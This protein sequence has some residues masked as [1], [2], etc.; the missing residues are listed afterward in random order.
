[1]MV[2]NLPEC[3]AKK[4]LRNVVI[5][6]CSSFPVQT[7]KLFEKFLYRRQAR[8]QE[9]DYEWLKDKMQEIMQLDKPPNYE[10]FK[11]SN[12]WVSSF[13]DRY[14]VSS[15]VQ[16]EKKPVSN[17][18][19]DP[20]LQNFHRET[21]EIQQGEGLNPRDPVYG[22]FSPKCIWNIDQ[23]PAS[24]IDAKRHSLNPKGQACWIANQG[25]AGLYKRSC[26]IIMT[27]R[28]EGEQIVPP[29][30]LFHGK[31]KLSPEIIA[32]LDEQ[33]I[34]YAFNKK[35][36]ADGATCIQHLKFVAKI[37]KEKCPEA[38]EHMLYLDGLSAQ[39]TI[40]FIDL[41]LDLSI[42]P[43][44]FPPNC[45]H[46]VQPVDH[47]VA[48]WFKACWHRLYLLEQEEKYEEWDDYQNNGS[49]STVYQRVTALRWTKLIWEQLK[50]MHGFLS[51]A[52]TST[53][54]L[55]KLNGEHSI[56]FPNIPNYV[57]HYPTKD[58]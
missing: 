40:R 50:T 15:Q 11:Y 13:V 38:K 34:P 37:L 19:K 23:I 47:R 6:D 55:I 57:F 35:A 26:T 27:L 29:F 42:L 36:W 8:G 21:C 53:G 32:E 18:L 7:D 25:A 3:R 1:M 43:V 2:A 20:I 54:C 56:K 39:A 44:Y 24:I 58:S 14:D 9:V 10:K 51:K 30:L 49:M 5:A 22:R 17:A 33:G 48:A 12:G 31:G 41:A 4:R 46:L 16:T 28:A 45:T 52:F